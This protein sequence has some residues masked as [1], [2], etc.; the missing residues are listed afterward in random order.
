MRRVWE[1][2]LSTLTRAAVS[3]SRGTVMRDARWILGLSLVGLLLSAREGVAPWVTVLFAW[4]SVGAFLLNCGAYVYSLLTAP[5]SLRSETFTLEKLKIE[6]GLMGDS[7][8]GLSDG[9]EGPTVNALPATATE[10]K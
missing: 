2:A 6:K 10:G 5:D 8:S 7:I 9:R 4:L 3:G 1:V